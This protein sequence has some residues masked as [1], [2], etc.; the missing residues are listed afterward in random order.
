MEKATKEVVSNLAGEVRFSGIVSEEK[1]DRQGNITRIAQRGGLIWVCA[2]EVYNLPP[3]AEA[4]VKN[5]DL[6]DRNSVLAETRV[7]TEH[8]GIVRCRDASAPEGEEELSKAPREVEIITASVILNNARVRAESTGSGSSYTIETGKGQL[9]SLK[10]T[11][12]TKVA[13]SQVV[14]E[15]IDDRYRTKTGGLIKYA[16]VEVQKKGA[17]YQAG[18]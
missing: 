12:G 18:L 8:G 16:G 4:V 15:L 3:G 10:A 9:F 13:N 5:G 17:R 2:G 11:P 6:V 7:V 14:A 1:T